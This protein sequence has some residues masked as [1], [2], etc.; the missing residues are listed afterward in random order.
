MLKARS[1][2]GKFNTI[3]SAPMCQLPI[4]QH[5]NLTCSSAAAACRRQRDTLDTCSSCFIRHYRAR[6]GCPLGRQQSIHNM[7]DEAAV[8]PLRLADLSLLSKSQ[9][10]RDRAT[11]C[12]PNSATNLDSVKPQSAERVRDVSSTRLRHDPLALSA[13]RQ[14]I[15]D[16]CGPVSPIDSV[17]TDY[18]CDS[19]AGADS[20]L[21]AIVA[22]KLLKSGLDKGAGIFDTACRLHPGHPGPQVFT[23]R[24]DEFEELLRMSGRQQF[25][26]EVVV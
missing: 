14:P 11:S 1:T 24:V 20:S 15:P 21:K 25:E 18:A 3:G 26:C 4:C 6:S 17:H 13:F 8:D 16:R 22:S 2:P 19:I 5:N 9:A 12:I 23:I 7:I 10:L